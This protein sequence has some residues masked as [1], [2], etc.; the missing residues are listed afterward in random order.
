MPVILLSCPEKWDCN[1]S[2]KRAKGCV[3]CALWIGGNGSVTTQGEMM[4][5]LTLEGKGT[6]E[7]GLSTVVVSASKSTTNNGRQS[8]AWENLSGLHAADYWIV[9]YIKIRS[10]ITN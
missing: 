9:W 7:T 1:L 2:H 6:G 3:K 10:E 5:H 4:Y 8:G